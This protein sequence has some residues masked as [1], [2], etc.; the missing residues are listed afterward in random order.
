MNGPL[1]SAPSHAQQ[2]ERDRDSADLLRQIDV[3]RK[4][5]ISDETWRRWRA[6]G[7]TPEPVDLPGVLRWRRQDVEAFM[8]RKRALPRTRH[9]FRSAER[10][11]R[12]KQLVAVQNVG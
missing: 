8:E 3:C 7:L 4:L 5:G 1:E 9:Y 10:Q 12:A 6:R 2:P 11:T